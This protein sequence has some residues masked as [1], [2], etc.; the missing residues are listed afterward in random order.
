MTQYITI[1]QA[2]I[3]TRNLAS[4]FAGNVP[5][6]WI[7]H[8]HFYSECQNQQGP[9]CPAFGGAAIECGLP[10]THVSCLVSHRIVDVLEL[11]Q[12]NKEHS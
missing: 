7:I 6:F 9:E 10:E 8:A 11:T 1:V 2:Y 3:F 12:V 4:H 5:L